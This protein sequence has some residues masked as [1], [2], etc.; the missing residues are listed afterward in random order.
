MYPLTEYQ[1]AVLAHVV[2]DPDAWAT[3]AVAAVGESAVVEK[4]EKYR[5]GYENEKARLGGSYQTR[6]QRGS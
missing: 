6:A 2:V 3:H 5:A 1:R 4:V